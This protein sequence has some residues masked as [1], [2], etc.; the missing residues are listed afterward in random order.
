MFWI[1]FIF[2]IMA[3]LEVYLLMK[4]KLRQKGMILLLANS[5]TMLINLIVMF[6]SIG[7]PYSSIIYMKDMAMNHPF[8]IILWILLNIALYSVLFF[9]IRVASIKKK[10]TRV[11]KG[12][13][14]VGIGFLF[15]VFLICLFQ[16]ASPWVLFL[17]SIFG[18]YQLIKSFVNTKKS[19]M[20]AFT[21]VLAM[22]FL[23]SF[24]TYT[25]AA[26]LQILLSGY[27]FKAYNT[28]LEELRYYKENNSKRYMPT[29]EIPTTSGD[30][31]TIEVKSY[32]LIKIGTYMGY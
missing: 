14:Y 1:F 20:L 21:I 31:G 22:A 13:L 29:S 23:Y 7:I 18:M 8:L 25:G 11:L 32:G 30:M 15:L 2:H 10:Q 6:K 3:Y 28:G 4:K 27:P 24:G 16:N 9:V 26:R 5:I 17:L 19:S 12:S